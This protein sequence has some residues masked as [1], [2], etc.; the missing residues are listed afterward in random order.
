V[1]A[2]PAFCPNRPVN[3]VKDGEFFATK[4]RKKDGDFSQEL[5]EGTESDGELQPR[6]TRN[7]RTGKWAVAIAPGAV[8]FEIEELL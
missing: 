2:A 6:N 3:P 5:T 4:G 7:T 1:E 8:N